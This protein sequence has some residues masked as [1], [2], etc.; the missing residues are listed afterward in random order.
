M[1]TIMTL[2]VR[3]RETLGVA[4][5]KARFSELLERVSRGERFVVARRGKPAAELVP[6]G[7]TPEESEQPRGLATLTGALA[8]HPEVVRELELVVRSRTS[9]RDRRVPETQ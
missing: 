9:A 2:M 6:P 4:D 5:A 7:K 8:D 1:M 3:E